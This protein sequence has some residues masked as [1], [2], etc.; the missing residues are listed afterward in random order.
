MDNVK[1]R[2]QK[3]TNSTTRTRP[4]KVYTKTKK[5]KGGYIPRYNSAKLYTRK[6]TIRIKPT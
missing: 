4:R 1:N 6:I 2:E 5:Q 3:A